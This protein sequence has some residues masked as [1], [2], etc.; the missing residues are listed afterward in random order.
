MN[1]EFKITN[2]L[3]DNMEILTKTEEEQD[4]RRIAGMG[5]DPDPL[6]PKQRAKRLKRRK[7]AKASRK[8]NRKRRNH[9]GKL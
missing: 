8:R 3:E 5:R 7:M 9:R 6:T 1:L 2:S 4:A